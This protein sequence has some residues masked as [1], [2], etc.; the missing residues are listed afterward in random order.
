[1]NALKQKNNQNI[2]L[3]ATSQSP[4]FWLSTDKYTTEHTSAPQVH[5]KSH[6]TLPVS[7]SIPG[8]R[9]S[10]HCLRLPVSLCCSPSSGVSNLTEPKHCCILLPT[11]DAVK[12]WDADSRTGQGNLVLKL[13]PGSS[14]PVMLRQEVSLPSVRRRVSCTVAVS[15]VSWISWYTVRKKI[16]GQF[17]WLH[18]SF[19]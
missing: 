10:V 13:I 4:T 17:V 2:Q 16:S 15:E 12:V 7:T 18:S 3:K 19:S 6:A 5:V 14:V 9:V 1:M 11:N 8:S